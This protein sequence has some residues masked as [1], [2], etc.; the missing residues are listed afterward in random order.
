[1]K[2]FV[3]S[4]TGLSCSAF[5]GNAGGLFTVN[6]TKLVKVKNPTSEGTCP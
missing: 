5:G 3:A 2:V 6:E 1:M 4:G